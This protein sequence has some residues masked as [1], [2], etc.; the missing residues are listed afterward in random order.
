ML[1]DVLQDA[2]ELC[3]FCLFC[4][5]SQ[6][7]CFLQALAT[8]CGC[9]ILLWGLHAGTYALM[10][11]SLPQVWLFCSAL[12]VSLLLNG[13]LIWPYIG[14]QH[15][16][17]IHVEMREL[18]PRYILRLRAEKKGS[19]PAELLLYLAERQCHSSDCLFHP[20]FCSLKEARLSQE[21]REELLSKYLTR[22]IERTLTP[23]D[24][25]TPSQA[26]LEAVRKSAAQLRAGIISTHFRNSSLHRFLPQNAL[27]VSLLLLLLPLLPLPIH[28]YCSIKVIKA[29]VR[30]SPALLRLRNLAT[31]PDSRHAQHDQTPRLS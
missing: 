27:H 25:S 28:A 14:L 4:P 29:D 8:G 2:L 11:R 13:L 9:F 21:Q 22:P 10:N 15:T 26:E 12:G 23:G 18:S 3:R 16:D 17:K 30:P 7:L 5:L 20:N 24:R 6:M 19:T 31:S 1:P